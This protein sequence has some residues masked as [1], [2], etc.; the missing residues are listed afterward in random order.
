M[1]CIMAML[2]WFLARLDAGQ[3]GEVRDHGERIE[4]ENR[5]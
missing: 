2:L 4:R 5:E 3:A 1:I